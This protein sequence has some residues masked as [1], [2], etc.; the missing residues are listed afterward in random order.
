[1]HITV[2]ANRFPPV[3]HFGTMVMVL[4]HQSILIIH[5]FYSEINSFRIIDTI[6]ALVCAFLI[7]L[8]Q[9]ISCVHRLIGSLFCIY[10]MLSFLMIL[11]KRHRPRQALQG[12]KHR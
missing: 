7:T 6:I 2:Q 1:M 5:H 11:S 3:I 8:G 9:Y 10:S 4:L 12:K